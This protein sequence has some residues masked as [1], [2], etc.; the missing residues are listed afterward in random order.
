[1]LIPVT[2]RQSNDSGGLTSL[3][4]QTLASPAASLDATPLDFTGYLVGIVL[5]KLRSVRAGQAEDS[6]RCQLNG[7]TGNNYFSQYGQQSDTGWTLSGQ[8]NQASFQDFGTMP[9]ATADSNFFAQFRY[10]FMWPA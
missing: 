10:E 6:V 8:T 9:A 2:I 1:M 5:V 7:D 4:S 3:Y